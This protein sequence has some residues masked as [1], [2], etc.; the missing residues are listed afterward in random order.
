MAPKSN[1]VYSRGQ[2]KFVAPSHQMIG[3]FDVE[4]ESEYVPP[5]NLTSILAARAT[6]GTNR[7]WLPE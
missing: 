4:Q 7:R 1:I 6:R 3:I 2:S 5:T